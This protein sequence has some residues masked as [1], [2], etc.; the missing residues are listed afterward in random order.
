M[1]HQPVGKRAVTAGQVVQY[2]D[3]GTAVGGLKYS[4][5]G[6][7]SGHAATLYGNVLHEPP[8]QGFLDL[9]EDFWFGLFKVNEPVDHL[10]LHLLGQLRQHGAGPR[11]RQ[12]RKHQGDRLRTLAG[13]GTGQLVRLGIAGSGRVAQAGGECSIGSS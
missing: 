13:Q 6:L 4:G 10:N 5:H 3:A 1:R 11:R 8:A 9:T 7:Q 12:V 2:A